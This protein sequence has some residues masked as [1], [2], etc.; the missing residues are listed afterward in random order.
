MDG[1]NNIQPLLNLP[2]QDKADDSVAP[3]TLSNCMT[4]TMNYVVTVPSPTG[5]LGYA[6]YVNVWLDYDRNGQWGDVLSCPGGPAQ[7][8]AVQNQEVSLSGPGSHT[9]TTPFFIP[10]NPH[11]ELCLWWRITLS[12]TPALSADGSGTANGHKFG[13]TED[14]YLCPHPPPSPTPTP[15]AT[16]TLTPTP[17]ATVTP[18]LSCMNPPPPDM[19]AWWTLDETSGATA[20]DIAGFPTN[21]THF[22]GPAPAPGMVAYGLSFDGTDDYVEVADDPSLNFGAGGDLTGTLTIDAWIKTADLGDVT[23]LV[24]KRSIVGAGALQLRG[25]ALFLSKGWLGF[26]L[27]DGTATDYVSTAF[28]ADGHW[29]HVAVSVARNSQT[30]GKFYL[31]G[32]PVS[33]PYGVFDPTLVPGSLTNPSPLRMGR[34]SLSFIT[35]FYDGILDEV[36]L[37]HR[38]LTPEEIGHIHGFGSGGKC[39]CVDRPPAMDVWFPLDEPIGATTAFDIAPPPTNGTYLPSNNRPSPWPGMVAGS[40]YFAENYVEVAD[41]SSLNFGKNFSIDTWI[42]TVDKVGVK[43]LVDKRT[44]GPTVQGYSLF[45]RDGRLGFQLANGSGPGVDYISTALTAFVADGAWHHLAATVDRW[46]ST[47]GVK[48]Y[49]DGYEVDHFDPTLQPGSLT[50]ASP[51]RLAVRSSS[52][53]EYYRGALDEVELFPRV[54]TPGEIQLIAG[55]RSNGKCKSMPTPTPTPTATRTPTPTATA[56]RTPTPTATRTPTPTATRTPTPTA[57]RTPTPTPTSCAVV[58]PPTAMTHWWP[59]DEQSGTIAHDIV[60]PLTNGTHLNGPAPVPGMVAF[61]LSFDGVD[62]CVEVADHSSL[63]FDLGDLTIDAWIKTSD[64]GSL[65][66]LVDKRVAATDQGY[67]LF[68]LGNGVLGFELGQGVGFSNIYV[69]TVFVADGQWHQV[70]VSVDRNDPA[71]GKFYI[72]G[73]HILVDDFD[74]TYQ[75][76]SLTNTSPLRMGCRS[77]ASKDFYLGILDEVELFP[78][79]LTEG[80]IQGIFQAGSCGKDKSTPTPTPTA[81]ATRTPTPTATRTPT[82]TATSTPTAT[83]TLFCASPEM[84][85]VPFGQF[86]MGCDPAHN[87]GDGCYSADELPLHTVTLDAYC[88]DK[89]EVT[90]AQ[91]A[92]CVADAG[93][94]CTPPANYSS[95]TRPSYYGNPIY[96]TY[97][98]IY[99]NWSQAGAYCHWAGKGLPSEARWEKAARGASTPRAYPWGGGAPTCALANFYDYYGSSGMHCVGDT[100]AVGIY[101]DGAS[102]Y[103]ALDMA[104]NVWEWVNDWYGANY[105]GVSPPIDPQGP[106]PESGMKVLRSGSWDYFQWFVRTASRRG[107]APDLV[108][109]DVGFR[110]ARSY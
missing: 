79:A 76:G 38:V 69:S 61:A 21:G 80:D 64:A 19:D 106:G 35:G 2:D 46:D 14:Y 67:A 71:G 88:I 34:S 17:T 9:F 32:A 5:G 96:D 39:K 84:V 6:A 92:L 107:N 23:I 53:T 62:D 27:A 105:Y 28:V 93:S 65:K 68:L 103:G 42:W 110:C 83:P 7:E 99:V 102:P 63:N 101:T 44:V 8:W 97:P 25:Y 75:S 10:A 51:L 54:L 1:G 47:A 52:L 24:D 95:L 43:R 70:A 33:G 73:V 81:T 59:L 57:T 85:L 26:Q 41:D 50:N 36:E 22:N 104:G 40:R 108:S 78:R 20:Y 15:T 56:T 31:D 89:T 82:P 74:P 49:V 77:T 91:Y 100:S 58:S 13:E 12:N 11:P 16:A 55:R 87:G 98:V 45:L 29:H 94:G 66:Y 90:N 60:N 30:G 3:P 72:D 18:T 86:Q 4:T 48:F 109:Y 37:F